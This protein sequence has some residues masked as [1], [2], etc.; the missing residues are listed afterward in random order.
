MGEDF[1]TKCCWCIPFP[2]AI[3][4]MLVFTILSCIG[5]VLNI[6]NA[7]GFIGNYGIGGIVMT[8]IVALGQLAALYCYVKYV[9]VYWP[10]HSKK[11]DHNDGERMGLVDA[12]KYLIYAAAA[13]YLSNGIAVLIFSIIWGKGAMGISYGISTI[14]SMCISVIISFIIISWWRNSF[15]NHAMVNNGKGPEGFSMAAIK[16]T[17]SE[18]KAG[19]AADAAKAKEDAGKAADATKDAAAS[20]T[21]P[22]A[23]AAAEVKA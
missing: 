19:A 18:T 2:C 22:A 16:A 15:K 6:V 3:T 4:T 1:T 7:I 23:D 9:Q 20:A 11:E 14:I 5:C 8:I 10:Y 17:F 13:M 21:A 12:F